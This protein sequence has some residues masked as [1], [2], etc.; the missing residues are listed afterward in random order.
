MGDRSAH[1]S[2]PHV[3]QQLARWA[4][5]LVGVRI[6]DVPTRTARLVWVWSDYDSA[7]EPGA[8]NVRLDE[9]SWRWATEAGGP[10][11]P[12]PP[13]HRNA[14]EP[15]PH[16]QGMPSDST[17]GVEGEGPIGLGNLA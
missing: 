2:V 14:R 7:L 5:G 17:V 9:T 1:Q 10:L 15:P 8:V 6:V 12:P 11:P 4:V 13:P 3:E 16:P